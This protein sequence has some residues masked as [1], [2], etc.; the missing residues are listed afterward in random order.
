MDKEY[1][2]RH[3]K[4]KTAEEAGIGWPLSV[5]L[6]IEDGKDAKKR[7]EVLLGYIPEEESNLIVIAVADDNT[8]KFKVG[9]IKGKQPHEMAAS[10]YA[11]FIQSVY[12]IARAANALDP[13]QLD[14]AIRRQ[15]PKRRG[16]PNTFQDARYD[17]NSHGR[18]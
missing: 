1:V 18:Y 14:G 15:L 11:T 8:K 4:K 2:M 6:S 7:H 10:A 13:H 3:I 17:S 5:G 16:T 9:K 12:V